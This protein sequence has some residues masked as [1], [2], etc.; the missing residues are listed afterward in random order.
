M[1]KSEIGFHLKRTLGLTFAVLIASAFGCSKADFSPVTGTVTMNGEPLQSVHVWFF[2]DQA[3]GM[4]SRGMTDEEGKFSLKSEDLKHD[5]AKPGNH[6]VALRDVW[7]MREY[8][9][10]PNS[11]DTIVVDIGEKSRISWDYSTHVNSPLNFT[12]ERDKPNHFDIKI[13]SNGKVIE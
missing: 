5:G 1:M 4:M 6:K 7:Y 3:E 8:K 13:S 12:V 9:I 2:P 11:G 10:D